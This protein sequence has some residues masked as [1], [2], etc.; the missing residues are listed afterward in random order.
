MV[1]LSFLIY[2]YIYAK[3]APKMCISGSTGNAQ[4]MLTEINESGAIAKIRI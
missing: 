2:I 4:R 3:G 1:L